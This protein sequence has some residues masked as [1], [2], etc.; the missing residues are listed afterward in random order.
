MFLEPGLW[1]L[2]PPGLML[3]LPGHSV[4][5][6]QAFSSCSRGPSAAEAQTPVVSCVV[7]DLFSSGWSIGLP[8]L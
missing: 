4:E 8:H 3:T 1:E 7:S 6:A 2:S 5:G